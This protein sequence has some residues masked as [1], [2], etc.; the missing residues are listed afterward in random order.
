MECTSGNSHV[1]IFEVGCSLAH[2]VESRNSTIRGSG[3]AVVS[4][5]SIEAANS[6]VR[7]RS[8][9]HPNPSLVSNAF[10]AQ[11]AVAR[12]VDSAKLLT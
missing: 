10:P 4:K 5:S 2:T 6:L 7:T 12:I 3:V 8:D 1:F 9:V 11:D